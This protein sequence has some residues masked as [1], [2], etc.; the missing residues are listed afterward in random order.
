MEIQLL[1]LNIEDETTNLNLPIKSIKNEEVTN[2]ITV[3]KKIDLTWIIILQE[4]VKV[5]EL[6]PYE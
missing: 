5:T 2:L 6:L 4:W 1:K 3:N